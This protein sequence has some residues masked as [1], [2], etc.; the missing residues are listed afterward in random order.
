MTLEE[1]A[2]AVG[3][4]L[5]L[6]VGAGWYAK[7]HA[8]ELAAGALNLANDAAG[9]AVQEAGTWIGL[10]KTSQTECERAIAEGR[11]WDASLLCPAGTFIGSIFG[12]SDPTVDLQVY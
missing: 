3:V 4:V 8:G 9:A 10:P 1:D 11:N 2:I 12:H 7:N 6:I 5:L